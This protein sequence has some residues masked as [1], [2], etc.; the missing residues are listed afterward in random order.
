MIGIGGVA[1]LASGFAAF[2]YSI[3]PPSCVKCNISM[4]VRFYRVSVVLGDWYRLRQRISAMRFHGMF[5]L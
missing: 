3:A 2:E 4:M 5:A 1:P